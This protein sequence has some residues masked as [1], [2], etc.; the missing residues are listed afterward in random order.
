MLKIL[1]EAIESIEKEQLEPHESS[2]L[3]SRSCFLD[4]GYFQG[5]AAELL[6]VQELTWYP[7]DLA[8]PPKS[9]EAALPRGPLSTSIYH[10]SIG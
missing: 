4:T 3:T 6:R 9:R 10:C 1:M 2:F 5:P 8:R 7:A